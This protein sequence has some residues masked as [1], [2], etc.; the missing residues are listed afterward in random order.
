MSPLTIK[1]RIDRGKKAVALAR[2]KGLDSILW[3]QD[4]HRL[5][6]AR[7]VARRT[8]QFIAIRGWC[9]WQCQALNNEIIVVARNDKVNGIPKDY[10]VYTEAELNKLCAGKATPEAIRLVHQAKKLT[11]AKIITRNPPTLDRLPTSHPPTGDLT[12][13]MEE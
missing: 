11:G 9:L 10:P 4:L 13:H 1:Q 2:E 7:E 6:Q 12:K 3:Q 5:E 8:R